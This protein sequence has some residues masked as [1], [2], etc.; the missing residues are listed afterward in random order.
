[1]TLYVCKNHYS[2]GFSSSSIITPTS[3]DIDLGLSTGFPLIA[4]VIKPGYKI[5]SPPLPVNW[6]LF[7]T[8]VQFLP[9]VGLGVTLSGAFIYFSLSCPTDLLLS[10]QISAPLSLLTDV[11]SI[12]NSALSGSSPPRLA[13][14][15]LTYC[16]LYQQVGII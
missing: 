14:I 7:I 2:L 10:D 3:S 8:V 1:M 12:Y 11:I 15:E 9:H 6:S 4:A 16:L 5:H 13:D